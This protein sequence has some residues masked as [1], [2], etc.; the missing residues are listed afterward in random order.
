MN[1]VLAAGKLTLPGQANI[2]LKNI[3]KFKPFC[4]FKVIVAT[5]S[6]RHS[7]IN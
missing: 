2:F 1:A 5:K 3:S 7:G 4:N 6:F